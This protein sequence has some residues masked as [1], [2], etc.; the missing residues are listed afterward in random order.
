MYTLYCRNGAGSQAVEALLAVCGA[1]YKTVVLDRNPDGSFP[2]WFHRI[3]PKA[4]VPA[5]ILPD[6]SVMTE[7]AAMLI[8]IAD[9]FPDKGYSPRQNSPKRAQFLRWMIYLATTVYMSD[10]RHFYPQRYTA[11]P[12]EADGIKAMAAEMMRKELAIYAAAL[13]DG[14]FILGNGLSAA[15]IYAAML[16]TWAPD[17]G[18]V[19]AAH[20]NLKAMYEAVTAVPAIKAVW[21]RNGA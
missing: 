6:D 20:S 11:K 1:D 17:M 15:D 5:L 12:A 2:D 10:L 19:F 16:I 13:G 18:Q 9:S 21:Q 4:E 8:H 3:N 14:P 7:S